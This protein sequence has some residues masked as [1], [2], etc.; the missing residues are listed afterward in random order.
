VDNVTILGGKA[1]QLSALAVAIQEQQP[2]EWT[3][4]YGRMTGQSPVDVAGL[5]TDLFQQ[6]TMLL[7]VQSESVRFQRLLV[8]QL[9]R[10]EL[11]RRH[12]STG[13]LGLDGCIGD[14]P[15]ARG[16]AR[17]AAVAAPAQIASEV[18][19]TLSPAMI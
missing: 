3:A 4:R 10:H 19:C 16:A 5:L 15:V 8:E 13:A 1:S 9:L 14:G 7:H 12:H 17:R 6:L 18:S 2:D 11:D